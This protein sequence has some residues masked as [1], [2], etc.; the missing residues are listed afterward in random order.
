MVVN[1]DAA[2]GHSLMIEKFTRAFSAHSR[3]SGNPEQQA[4][5]FATLGPRVPPSLFEL[6]R[7]E[8]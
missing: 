1:F 4:L 2:A 3:V 7:T 6:R 8:T 5:E